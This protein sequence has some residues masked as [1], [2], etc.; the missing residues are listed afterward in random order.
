MINKHN[1]TWGC[2]ICLKPTDVLHEVVFG[3]GRRKL[4]VEYNIQC[5]TCAEHHQIFHGTKRNICIYDHEILNAEGGKWDKVI[6]YRMGFPDPQKIRLALNQ[7]DTEF[8]NM[9]ANIGEL[10]LKRCEI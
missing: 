9:I 1:K 5:P 4:A 7:G 6:C 10:M 8:L 2:I 3:T